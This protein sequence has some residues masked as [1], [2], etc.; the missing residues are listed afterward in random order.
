MDEGRM[1][2]VKTPSLERENPS[3]ISPRGVLRAH[4]DQ[5]VHT[6]PRYQQKQID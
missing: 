1:N 6:I 3:R 2:S 4:N 5:T